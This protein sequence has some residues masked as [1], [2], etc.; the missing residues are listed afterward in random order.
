[1]FFTNLPMELI[2]LVMDFINNENDSLNWGAAWK[3]W[4]ASEYNPYEFT[5]YE[6][7]GMRMKIFGFDT[8]KNTKIETTLD[9]DI[10]T[11]LLISFLQTGDFYPNNKIADQY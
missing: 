10:F 3:G 11:I 5:I 8:S 4:R 6:N 1:M 9:T 7:P 2:S